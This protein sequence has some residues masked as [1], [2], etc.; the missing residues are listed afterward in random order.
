[1]IAAMPTV[2]RDMLLPMWSTAPRMLAIAD[3]ITRVRDTGLSTLDELATQTDVSTA[4]GVWLDYLGGRLGL[5]RPAITDP[6][7]DDR[8]GFDEAGAGFDQYPFAGAAVNEQVFPMPDEAF[9]CLIRARAVTV[10][11]DGTLDAFAVA[12]RCVDPTATVVDNFDMTVR[13]VTSQPV[14]MRIADLVGALPRNAAVEMV[15]AGRGRVGF[16][17]AGVP[18]DSGGFAGATS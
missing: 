11:A 14:L 18:L 6:T 12:A 1:M 16:D 7:L 15:V 17:E 9:R 10:L 8:F 13:V 4:T 2:L 3:E 5:E